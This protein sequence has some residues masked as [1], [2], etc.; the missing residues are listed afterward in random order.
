MKRSLAVILGCAIGFGFLPSSVSAANLAQVLP[1]GARLESSVGV[2]HE[3]GVY[4]VTYLF[5]GP[6]LGLISEMNGRAQL[7]WSRGLSG[8]VTRLATGNDHGVFRAVVTNQEG[9]KVLY[10]YSFTHHQVTSVISGHPAGHISASEAI[11]LT[12]EGFDLLSHDTTHIGSVAYRWNATYHWRSGSYVT[13][14]RL[15][16]PDYAPGQDPT[17]NGIV[18]TQS[19]DTTLI[20]LQVATTFAQQEQGLMNVKSMDPDDGMVFVWNQPIHGSFWMKDTYIPLTIAFLA[21]DGTIQEMQDMQPLTLTYHTPAAAF[22]YAV[23][24]NLGFFAANGIKVGDRVELN[25][26]S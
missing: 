12:P 9:K 11:S 1:S 21:P 8:S 7:V 18:H 22:Q 3:P 23:E 16:E 19:G 10:A 6:R 20:K 4:A 17:P 5:H 2:H 13:V 25:L 14:S 26:G 24:A 15:H